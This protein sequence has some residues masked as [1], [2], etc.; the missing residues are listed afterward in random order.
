MYL[1]FFENPKQAVRCELKLLWEAVD[2]TKYGTL[3]LLIAFNN[4]L[5]ASVL[6]GKSDIEP[7][8]EKIS[9]NLHLRS[10]FSTRVVKSELKN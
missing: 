10:Y 9:D 6:K 8:L 2:Q 1:I 4:C 3:M 7:I 5:Q